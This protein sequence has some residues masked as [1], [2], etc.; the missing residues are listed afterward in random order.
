M[1]K[2]KIKGVEDY[3]GAAAGWAALKA[4]ADALRG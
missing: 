4:V 3:K 2:K 1:T